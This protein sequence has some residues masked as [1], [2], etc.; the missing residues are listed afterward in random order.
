MSKVYFTTVLS[1]TYLY[2]G[3]CM[4]QTLKRH[5]S[6]FKLFILC[7][8]DECYRIFQDMKLADIELLR[9]E[10]IE[11]VSI[12]EAKN[13]R[14]YLEF[15]WTLKPVALYYVMKNYRNADYYAH[16]DADLYFF[17]DPISLFMEKPDAVLY[18]VDHNNSKEFLQTY[19]TSGRFN[20]GFVGCRNSDTARNAVKW[21]RDRCVQRCF[22]TPDP[23]NKLFGDQR[24]VERWLELFDGVHVV[25]NKGA[26][27]AVWNIRGYNI[28][29][30]NDGVY[31]DDN[32][33]IFYH[34]SGFCILNEN[35]FSLTWFQPIEENTLNL[36]YLPYMKH[37]RENIR[38]VEL[39]HSTFRKGFCKKDNAS[40]IQLYMV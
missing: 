34:F 1:C 13:N 29:S 36:I 17:A 8:D 40:K 39:R 12:R 2:K 25:E 33:L 3:L 38:S 10:Q 5:C 21:W 32:P 26:N 9:V 31:V 20:T 6:N 37:L 19:E 16:L 18:L 4:Y 35:E 27:V 11:N 30:K 22:S 14:S 24:Y 28:S 23:I 7:A 15:C